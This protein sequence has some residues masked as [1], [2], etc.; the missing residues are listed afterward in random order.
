MHKKSNGQRWEEKRRLNGLLWKE[1]MCV[2][3]CVCVHAIS[4]VMCDSVNFVFLLHFPE[5]CRSS[6]MVV[7]EVIRTLLGR[8]SLT[9]RSSFTQTSLSLLLKMTLCW[10]S[11]PYLSP[12]SPLRFSSCLLSWIMKLKIAWFTPG[13]RMKIILVS[14]C[15]KEALV[16]FLDKFTS[17]GSLRN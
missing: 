4:L 15:L 13:Y 17:S 16:V 8:F 5:T 10:S 1:I 3:V 2:C 6:F 9:R 14:E 11:C 7:L 12:F